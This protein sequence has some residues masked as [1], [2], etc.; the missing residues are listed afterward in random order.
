M[1]AEGMTDE[2]LV[3]TRMIHDRYHAYKRNPFNE[4][5]G[6]NHYARAMAS[7]GTFVTACGF[8]YHGPKGYIAFAPKWN[9]DNF[10][11][12]FVTAKGWGTYSQKKEGSS[13]VHRFDLK[14]GSLQ[15]KKVRLEKLNNQLA[16]KVSLIIGSQKLTTQFK[17]EGTSLLV[18]LNKPLLLQTNQHL[19][20]HIQ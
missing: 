11:A 5:G 12:P 9:A 13:Q 8:E 1:M 20:I 18:E 6:S 17:Q 15:L 19:I 14:Y 10:K 4:V 2:A 3:M 7:Y 16:Q